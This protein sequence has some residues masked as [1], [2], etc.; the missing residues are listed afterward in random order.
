M[1]MTATTKMAPPIMSRVMMVS[2]VRTKAARGT[3]DCHAFLTM[4]R[5]S[6]PRKNRMA[7]GEVRCHWPGSGVFN[8]CPDL[9]ENVDAE[10]LGDVHTEAADPEIAARAARRKQL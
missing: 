9:V 1:T 6:L 7:R 4:S 2:P 5:A 10:L 8:T 3:R